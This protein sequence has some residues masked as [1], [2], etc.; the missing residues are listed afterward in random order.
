MGLRYY[1][2]D[3]SAAGPSREPVAVLVAGN[4]GDVAL[5]DRLRDV[6][7]YTVMVRDD[8]EAEDA[9]GRGSSSRPRVIVNIQGMG[10]AVRRTDPCGSRAGV[11]LGSGRPPRHRWPAGAGP[12]RNRW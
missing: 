6:H 10:V 11:R 3:P 4:A 2:P 7:G 8:R 9:A 5:R 1:D 12:W